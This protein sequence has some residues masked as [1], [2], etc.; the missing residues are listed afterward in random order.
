MKPCNTAMRFLQFNAGKYS[1]KERLLNLHVG[2]VC[3]GIMYF[4]V[5]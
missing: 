4:D 2:R 3:C 1:Y 5:F